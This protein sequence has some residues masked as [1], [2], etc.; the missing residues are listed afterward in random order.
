[1]KRVRSSKLTKTRI[2]NTV[3]IVYE[4]L[5]GFIAIAGFLCLTAMGDLKHPLAI[6]A[7]L[8]GIILMVIGAYMMKDFNE[9]EKHNSKN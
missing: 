3:L 7:I 4:L 2:R 8:V 5:A 9:Y 6:P 1:M